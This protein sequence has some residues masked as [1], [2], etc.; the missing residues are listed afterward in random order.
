[1]YYK[2]YGKILSI[3]DKRPGVTEVLV[4]VDGRHEKA[5]NYDLLTGEVSGGE[6]V[7]LNTTAL[8]RGLGTGG[9]HFVME[10]AGK[11][12]PAAR[13]AGH[14]M[15]LRYTPWQLKVLSVEEEEHPGS[16]LYRSVGS[17]GGMP[18]IIASLHS[19]IAPVAAAVKKS[20]GRVLRVAYLMTDGAALPIWFSRLVHQLRDRDLL[21]S[22]ITCGHAF[23]GDHEAINVFSG[24]IWAKA[25][26]SDLVIVSM[27]PGI[28]G[29]GTQ[30]GNTAIEQGEVVNAVN[31]LGGRAI[32]V[33]RISF[34]D[35]RERHFGLSHHTMTSLGRIALGECTVPIPLLEG[36]KRDLIYR[37]LQESG[38]S[39]RHNIVE[40]DTEGLDAIMESL[41][42]RVTTMGRTAADDP[43]F[44]HTA[45]AAGFYAADLLNV[46]V[47]HL[48]QRPEGGRLPL[49][50]GHQLSHSP[51][52]VKPAPGKIN[53]H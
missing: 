1:M 15:K 38:I 3:I 27:G 2:K 13:T 8:D 10:V 29:S 42:L 5:I 4:E 19:M 46:G 52:K 40:V 28:V 53:L 39:Q 7:V 48:S 14:I 35:S 41:D 23:G 34:A 18:V 50:N 21:D 51:G 43:C 22:T 26:G 37:Q 44:F 17:M 47:D 45:G 11:S 16:G 32:A 30:F 24:L 25:A 12:K 31:V 36:K 33:P 9:Y 20:A 6:R 49:K